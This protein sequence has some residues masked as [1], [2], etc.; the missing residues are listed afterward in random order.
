MTQVRVL[1]IRCFTVPMKTRFPFRYGIASLTEL[2]HLLM[3]VQLEVDG[4]VEYGISADGLPPK[5]FTKNPQTQFD[6]DDLPQMQL[7]IRRAARSALEITSGESWFDWWM[8]LYAATRGM[9]ASTGMAPL[10][11]GFGFSLVER[12]VLH[13][14]CRLRRASI[15]DV[16][17]HNMLQL[18]GAALRPELAGVPLGQC[19]SPAPRPFIAV[20]HTIGLGDPLTGHDAAST[21]RPNDGLPFTLEENIR[22]YGLSYFKIKLSGDFDQDHH[23]LRAISEIIR[24]E[25]VVRPRVTV[26]GNENYA[27]ISEFRDHW[28][29]HRADSAIQEFLDHSLLF[30]EQPLHRD[31]ALGDDVRAALQDWAQAPPVIIDESDAELSSLPRALELGYA[32]TSHKNCKGVIK[33]LLNAATLAAVRRHGGAGILSAEDL[34][35][36][37][38][39]ALLQDLAVVA[40]LGMTHVERNG[41]HYFAGLSMFGRSQQEQV[42]KDHPDLFGRH[43]TGFA[44]VR[45]RDGRLALGSVNAAPFG[46]A[47]LPDRDSLTEW[48]I[49]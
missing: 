41:H 19:L 9:A 3:Q 49:G 44:A 46:V 38:P 37:G 25:A 2:P 11:A 39:V 36:V 20:R 6:D 22:E 32:G 42:L 26:D 10:M 21:Q 16:F 43:K 34:A 8:Q 14:F 29:A 48:E 1:Q 28:Q 24:R 33:G 13:A 7:S 27:E 4:V 30:V 12:A 18:D 47:E 23:R 31:R 15:H 17:C 35:N 5:W 40:C 45:I